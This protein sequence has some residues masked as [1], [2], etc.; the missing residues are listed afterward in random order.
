MSSIGLCDSIENFFNRAVSSYF[1]HHSFSCSSFINDSSF[2]IRRE[3]KQSLMACPWCRDGPFLDDRN[4]RPAAPPPTHPPETDLHPAADSG[5]IA[6]NDDTAALD[7]DT[8]GQTVEESEKASSDLQ[9][10]SSGRESSWLAHVFSTHPNLTM[11][12]TRNQGISA[13]ISLASL[14]G[15]DVA[16]DFEKSKSRGNLVVVFGEGKLMVL[17]GSLGHVVV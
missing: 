5:S 1:L 17:V 3:N 6:K 11:E 10:L 4:S 15:H 14:H 12:Q 9:S 7:N 2:S 8:R 13:N 16:L